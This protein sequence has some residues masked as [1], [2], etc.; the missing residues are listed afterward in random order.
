MPHRR[1]VRPA[2]AA[3]TSEIRCRTPPY[4]PGTGTSVA[5]VPVSLSFNQGANF[6]DAA[7]PLTFLYYVMAVS[8]CSPLGGPTAGDTSLSVRGVGFNL[9]GNAT[10]IRAKLRRHGGSA[11]EAKVELDLGAAASVSSL[12]V[13]SSL[14]CQ[15]PLRVFSPFASLSTLSAAIQ[16][17][18]SVVRPR[19]SSSE[20]TCRL[21]SARSAL[22]S[23]QSVEVRC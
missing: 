14:C 11:P 20:P 16:V 4:T 17:T 19:R 13:P 10:G 21:S 3:S 1:A 5:R 7:P 6:A 15:P 8:A 18:I 9:G 23:D 12:A 22:P 2:A